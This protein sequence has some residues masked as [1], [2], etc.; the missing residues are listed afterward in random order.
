MSVSVAISCEGELQLTETDVLGLEVTVSFGARR[1]FELAITEDLSLKALL[2]GL[3]KLVGVSER[4][5]DLPAPFDA[6]LKFTLEP[7]RV[8]GRVVSPVLRLTPSFQGKPSRAEVMVGFG[9][10]GRTIDLLVVKVTLF[11]IRAAYGGGQF[12]L[13][14]DIEIQGQRQ[15]VALPFER[16]APR[17]ATF[18]LKYLALGQ[19][20]QVPGASEITSVAAAVDAIEQAMEIPETG[21]E[22]TPIGDWYDANSNWLFATHFL[23][24]KTLEFRGI[25]NDPVLYGL[26]I[27]LG[28][29][30]G[31]LADL[32]FEILY[33]KITDDIGEYF[34]DFALPSKVRNLQLGAAQITLPT[35][36]ISIYTN[37]DFRVALGWPLGDNSLIIQAAGFI[38]GGGFYF[39]KLS[40]DVV[41][42]LSRYQTI[43]AFGLALTIGRGVRIVKG[44]LTAE[45]SVSIYGVFEGVLA[46][47]AA[48]KGE[49]D[50]F[51]F[52]A[53]VGIIGVLEGAVDFKIIRASVTVR[54]TVSASLIFVPPPY[55]IAVTL[56]A[57]VDIAVSL[58]IAFIR[59]HFSFHATLTHT[60]VL[61]HGKPLD[62]RL[63]TLARSMVAAL[64]LAAD[65]AGRRPIDR[66]A[67]TANEAI[68]A[69]GVTAA[70]R[71]SIPL[72]FLPQVTVVFADGG[73]AP[74]L[75][76]SLLIRTRPEPS[77]TGKA[78]YDRLVDALVAAS[79]S[80]GLAAVA[81]ADLAAVVAADAPL[82]ALAASLI[83]ALGEHAAAQRAAKAG[84]RRR[85][86]EVLATF[87]E[88][89]F[90]LQTLDATA[91]AA[92]ALAADDSPGYT[93]FPLFEEV[94]IAWNNAV[95]DPDA[96]DPSAGGETRSPM[97]WTAGLKPPSYAAALAAYFEALTTAFRQPEEEPVLATMA[98][99]EVPE[100]TALIVFTD[101][102]D[103]VRREALARIQESDEDKPDLDADFRAR[104][105]AATAK[106][107]DEKA[108]VA[109]GLGVITE[110]FQALL[111]DW[112]E[113][114]AAKAAYFLQSG[115]RLPES[116]DGDIPGGIEA[117]YQM[118]G[119]QLPLQLRADTAFA[120][121]L[122]PDPTATWT[123]DATAK[124]VIVVP[125]KAAGGTADAA[126]GRTPY[127]RRYLEQMASVKLDN[128]VH[129]FEVLNG[130]TPRP[131]VF[132]LRE[133]TTWRQVAAD[134]TT[135]TEQRIVTITAQMARLIV[136]AG[137]R[138]ALFESADDVRRFAKSPDAQDAPQPL[139]LT[140]ALKIPLSLRRLRATTGAAGDG[141]RPVGSDDIVANTYEIGGT[142]ET[143]RRLLNAVLT[144]GGTDA[145]AD[146]TLLFDGNGDDD[147]LRAQAMDAAH[148]LIIKTNLST[149]SGPPPMLAMT[150]PAGAAARDDP[151]YAA[152]TEHRPLLRLIWEL[153]I[154]NSGG[155][156][157]YYRTTDGDDF[158]DNLFA[159]GD[160]VAI[161]LL[162]RFT[163]APVASTFLATPTYGKVAATATSLVPVPDYANTLVTRGAPPAPTA[164][165][166]ARNDDAENAA[167]QQ[168]AAML[169]AVSDQV[170]WDATVP[171]GSVGFRILRPKPVEPDAA[172]ALDAAAAHVATLYSLMQFR[173][174]A[175]GDFRASPWSVPFGPAHRS[176]DPDELAAMAGRARDP[177]A[178]VSD[179]PWWS[180]EQTP[181]V[182][183]FIADGATPPA[184]RY[185]AVGKRLSLDFRIGDMFGNWLADATPTTA[186]G[187]PLMPTPR[188]LAY[189][190]RLIG[191][192]GLPGWSVTYAVAKVD[193]APRLRLW[194]THD[195]RSLIPAAPAT[196]AQVEAAAAA[197]AGRVPATPSQLEAAKAAWARCRLILDQ[198]SDGLQDGDAGTALALRTS[199]I[200][201]G[202]HALD[203]APLIG[204]VRQTLDFV[205]DVLKQGSVPEP[206]PAPS[207]QALYTLALDPAL[208]GQPANLFAVEVSVG[209]SRTEHLGEDVD[210]K[211]PQ[212]K[213]VMTP[214]PPRSGRAA[215]EAGAASEAYGLGR[216]AADFADA[217]GGA[218]RLALG[219]R[220]WGAQAGGVDAVARGMTLWAVRLGKGGITAT[221][222]LH[223]DAKQPTPLADYFAPPP[224]C[225]KPRTDPSPPRLLDGTFA[226][227]D[228]AKA[229]TG[230]GAG[231]GTASSSRIWDP[232]WQR[233]EAFTGVDLDVWGRA[234]LGAVDDLLAPGMAVALV[235]N[236]PGCAKYLATLP[237]HPDDPDPP[238][239]DDVFAALLKVKA[240]LAE[241]VSETLAPVLEPTLDGALSDLGEA[242]RV[243]KERL[244]VDLSA[245]Y[246][247]SAIVQVPIDVGIAHPWRDVPKFYGAV[248]A[249]KTTGNGSAAAG[250][251]AFSVAKLSLTGD[252]T[253]APRPLTFLFTAANPTVQSLFVSDLGFEVDFIEHE[254]ATTDSPGAIDGYLPS[255]WLKLIAPVAADGTRD[256]GSIRIP[257]GRLAVPVALREFPKAPV[258]KSQATL[259]PDAAHA[260][261]LRRILDWTYELVFD[262]AAVAQDSIDLEV[263]YNERQDVALAGGGR[264]AMF[265]AEE[266]GRPAPKDLFEGLARFT[267][268]YPQ[269]R[270]VFERLTDG[271]ASAEDLDKACLA[272]VRAYAL[273]RDVAVAWLDRPRA[274]TMLADARQDLARIVDRYT[275]RNNQTDV[276]KDIT[277]EA[278]SP[279]A[280]LPTVSFPGV[281]GDGTAPAGAAKTY[282]LPKGLRGKAWRT[283]ALRYPGRNVLMRQNA[284][285]QMRV[286]RNAALGATT[287]GG[288][289]RATNGRFQYRTAMVRFPD[290]LTPLVDRAEEIKV[291]DSPG[292][293]L[294]AA[295]A[296]FLKVLLG[297]GSD[298]P[299]AAAESER[300]MK[301]AVSYAFDVIAAAGGPQGG[302]VGTAIRADLPI[303]MTSDFRFT[304]PTDYD[305]DNAASFVS[306]LAAAI[307]EWHALNQPAPGSVLV[308]DLTVF[309]NLSQAKL[310]LLRLRRL[311]LPI[312]DV[313][314]AWWSG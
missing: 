138:F 237:P 28:E 234:V 238:A 123:D 142:D 218:I 173:I 62:F 221:P 51:Y 144:I 269:L 103:L 30:A 36:Q 148:S 44:P 277:I 112:Y 21:F 241:A 140:P 74:Q 125:A 196:E 58:K 1:F 111:A 122:A 213:S 7:Q 259:V 82:A 281:A 156:L 29:K 192:D 252:Q 294:R 306:R 60:F 197:A 177:A 299:H 100:S 5:L 93:M 186:D 151:Q 203:K 194:F 57:G 121:A 246:D 307:A 171:P 278:A 202:D 160:A 311:V 8:Q 223:E 309:A 215:G 256:S 11:G 46:W 16:P 155:F 268:E 117:L 90:R 132:A 162:V 262:Q 164:G 79:V 49:P 43:V 78:D 178:I 136:T 104:F 69:A 211:N 260:S 15:I 308:F 128:S 64:T 143:S 236:A 230:A 272:V 3:L 182:F 96:D 65:A 80:D 181:A 129:S 39:A 152:F 303:L 217:F 4:M 77:G 168:H 296:A 53:T 98:A 298:D 146:I 212:A 247:V 283:L 201:G 266:P 188:T 313:A 216:F 20:L 27:S 119:L 254:I 302:T 61:Q 310:P 224:L 189:W 19:R 115:L 22:D 131:K 124:G 134:G 70:A 118:S 81:F 108:K 183:R 176:T 198:L 72:F 239:G 35:V 304:V 163:A 291:A 32:R 270:P 251:V 99:A 126:S 225:P 174:S 50:F 92:A 6:I 279:G 180:Y 13:A 116:F 120:A 23:I 282:P 135:A 208:A 18:Q 170:E 127:P 300:L 83:Q 287:G 26:D 2:Q 114:I 231:T 276:F 102:W 153:S 59:V 289:G 95:T 292:T 214:L 145:V 73:P 244:L 147:V 240:D 139:P 242:K 235:R 55:Q 109:A 141:E 54:L 66:L 38:G 273:V 161:T 284:V 91:D 97:S 68:A 222:A 107:K 106:E 157:L 166:D 150:M 261:D 154:V 34:I 210:T 56:H 88:Y 250:G 267:A 265:A 200:P 137:A 37:G 199:L 190:D 89:G 293:G 187:Q 17:T 263:I 31:V 167:K 312:A 290:V 101:Y 76:A 226:V 42:A 169:Y 33:K 86:A 87:A 285:S 133:M 295:M 258:L 206:L 220:R 105:A 158:P 63:Q 207:E 48:A 195:P 172:D 179:D 253:P 175:D 14:A 10:D 85:Y 297:P 204:A 165:D 274:R 227:V 52:E 288:D 94:V 314:P 184:N 271:K 67:G 130:L 25:F 280:S 45:L 75:V 228:Y 264:L 110:T 193:G 149:E 9:D 47:D 84:A 243:F 40:G 301:L 219:R 41:P 229:G 255:S 286:T 232:A 113:A 24:A 245:A 185:A 257:L 159:G 275:I 12:D 205:T 209:L 191:V 305:P 71:P 249:G 248:T 233:D